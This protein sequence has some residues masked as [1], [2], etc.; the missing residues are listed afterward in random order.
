MLLAYSTSEVVY[1]FVCGSENITKSLMW[2]WE[3]VGEGFR[4]VANQPMPLLRNCVRAQHTSMKNEI[5]KV[6]MWTQY[7]N[8]K[9]GNAH[10]PPSPSLHMISCNNHIL[11]RQVGV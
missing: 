7:D 6:E 11:S 5:C 10:W 2:N 8:T 3:L 9:C 1:L 4:C